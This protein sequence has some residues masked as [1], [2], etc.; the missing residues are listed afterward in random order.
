MAFRFIHTADIHLD[1]PLRSLALKNDEAADLVANATRRAFI[2]I[3]DLCIDE[4]V[5]ALIIAG[6]LYDG[7]LNSMKTA[8]FFVS[9]M[10]RLVAAGILAFVLRG[11]HDAESRVTRHIRVPEGVHVFSSRGDKVE[12][13]AHGVVIH[14]L[15]F[16]KP[17]V[18]ESLL[19]KYRPAEAGLINIGV[20]HTSLAGSSQHDPYSPCTVEQLHA[21]GYTYWALGHIHKRDVHIAGSSTV[22][23]PGIPQG[24]HINEAGPRSVTLVS[25]D[26]NHDV[27][28]EERRSHSVQFERV[29][30]DVTGCN[31]WEDLEALLGKA[32]DAEVDEHNVRGELYLIVRVTLTGESSL[33]NQLRRDREALAELVELSA[34]RAGSVLIEAVVN[35]ITAVKT[36]EP[37]PADLSDPLTELDRIVASAMGDKFAANSPT[38]DEAFVILEQLQAALPAELR[39]SFGALDQDSRDTLGLSAAEGAREILAR[40]ETVG[41]RQ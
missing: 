18:P 22:V 31:H 29:E 20:L 23:M 35:Q 30:I 11:N 21:Q 16:S 38:M 26:D 7:E 10:E 15:S 37:T 32:F 2:R 13:E 36:A 5:D 28:L 24:R 27:T 33:A 17:H 19:G 6:D 4:R 14:G 8:A 34:Q 41:E 25:I 1:S 12:L 40:L 39:E 3:I 9:E